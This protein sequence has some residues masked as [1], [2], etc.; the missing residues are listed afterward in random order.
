MSSSKQRLTSAQG[1]R[2]GS[3]R[4]DASLKWDARSFLAAHFAQRP[5]L[6]RALSRDALAFASHRGEA[7]KVRTKFGRGLYALR[8]P[9]AASEYLGLALYRVRVSLKTAHIPL[10]PGA[11]SWLCA[12]AWGIRIGDPVVVQGGVYIPH[13]QIVLDGLAVIETGCVLCPW[14]TIGLVQGDRFGPRSEEGLFGPRLEEGVFVGTGAKILGHVRVGAQARIGANA[15][16]LS[17]VPA[18]ATAV[19]VPARIILPTNSATSQGSAEAVLADNEE[20]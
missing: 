10:I 14:V 20:G 1:A 15:V 19:G 4:G 12:I 6:F 5:P 17:D 2:A 8:L 18:W 16:V 11:L 9:F 3:K 7:A 13:G